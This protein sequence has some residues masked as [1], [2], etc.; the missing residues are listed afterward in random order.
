MNKAV[1]CHLKSK[2][3][4]FIIIPHA[5]SGVDV[6]RKD[7]EHMLCVRNGVD[8]SE[9]VGASHRLCLEPIAKE[10][11]LFKTKLNEKGVEVIVKDEL[12][13]QRL[14]SRKAH[15]CPVGG[16]VLSEIESKKLAEAKAAAPAA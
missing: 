11:R 6:F 16:H 4:G 1:L 7:G 10:A 5:D 9:Q 15:V 13:N 2:Y 12:H 3:K 8:L 14:E